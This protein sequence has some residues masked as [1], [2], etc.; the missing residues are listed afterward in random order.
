VWPEEERAT[1]LPDVIASYE[2]AAEE[3]GAELLPAGAAWSAAWRR[4]SGLGLYGAD[5]FHPSELGT[6][7]A[8]LVVYAG[9]TGV[10][11]ETLPLD[12][13]VPADSAR[14]LRDAAAE[15]LAAR[16]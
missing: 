7:L 15:A 2:A 9:L 4:D 3:S 1:A 8:A 11:P 10:S 14:I 5:G 6:E 16:S 12:D 13:S